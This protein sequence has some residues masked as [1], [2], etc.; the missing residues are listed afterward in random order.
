MLLIV[1]KTVPCVIKFKVDLMKYFGSLEHKKKKKLILR[2]S[3]EN[4]DGRQR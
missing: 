2:N 1:E 4:Q 3:E